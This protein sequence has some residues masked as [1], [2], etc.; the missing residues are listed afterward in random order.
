M[1]HELSIPVRLK[2]RPC[3]FCGHKPRAATQSKTRRIVV[4]CSNE[5]CNNAI[6][7]RDFSGL[8]EA[9][10]YWNFR[11]RADTPKGQH[12]EGSDLLRRALRLLQEASDC[13]ENARTRESVQW[14]TQLRRV[15]PAK[16][17]EIVTQMHKLAVETVC[18]DC[19]KLMADC[20]CEWSNKNA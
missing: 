18:E 15:G 17:V 11:S 19:G 14:D 12:A 1:D 13:F 3:A 4:C 20:Q 8:D 9:L 6:F 7:S 2:V 10:A 16:L 5:S